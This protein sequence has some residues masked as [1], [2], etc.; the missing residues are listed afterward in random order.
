M[1]AQIYSRTYEQYLLYICLLD[2]IVVRPN[3]VAVCDV[4]GSRWSH[5]QIL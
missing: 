4:V 1:Y 5:G 3:G 2:R